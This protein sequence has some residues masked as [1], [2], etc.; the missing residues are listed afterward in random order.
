MPAIKGDYSNFILYGLILFDFLILIGGFGYAF[1]IKIWNAYIWK[2]TLVIYPL[3]IIFDTV[4]DFY[5]GGYTVFEMF[6]HSL[7]VVFLT[8]IFMAPV[9]M[10]LKDFKAVKDN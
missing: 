2:V 8:C 7:F 6:T 3:L 1:K 4:Y 10:Y 9:I 5:Q